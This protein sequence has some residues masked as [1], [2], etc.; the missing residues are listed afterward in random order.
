MGFEIDHSDPTEPHTSSTVDQSISGLRL[1]ALE[2]GALVIEQVANAAKALLDRNA[3]LA[4]S[5]LAREPLVDQFDRQLDHDSLT[6]IA[7][8]KPVANDLRL[9]RAIVRMGR[10]LERAGD[11]AKKIARFALTLEQATGND[12]VLAVARHLRHMASLSVSMLRSAVRAADEVDPA[13]AEAV[14]KRDAE[15]DAEFAAALRQIMSYVLQD[16]RFLRPTID[17]IFALKGLERIGDHATN[18]AE[19]VL[20]MVGREPHADAA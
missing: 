2:M 3:A 12:P 1:H 4:Q 6:F 16:H 7:L 8:Q 13:M 5:V 14:L 18:V 20:Y 17:T 9:S 19:Q 15:L 10:E 11:E